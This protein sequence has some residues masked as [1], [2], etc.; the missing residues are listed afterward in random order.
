MKFNN[1]VAIIRTRDK[2]RVTTRLIYTDSYRINNPCRF[3]YISEADYE[4]DNFSISQAANGDVLVRTECVYE[5]CGNL[6]VKW[7]MHLRFSNVAD[8]EIYNG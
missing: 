7:T 6:P 4:C 8:V 3:A 1:A 2:S 5:V